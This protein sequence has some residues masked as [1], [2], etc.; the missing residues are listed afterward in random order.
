MSI[1]ISTLEM[2]NFSSFFFLVSLIAALTTMG[3]CSSSPPAA[4]KGGYYPSWSSLP[5]WEINTT[6]FTHIFYAFL[7]PSTVTFKFEVTNETA[8]AVSNFTTTLHYKN[9]P[10]KTLLSIGGAGADASALL[11]NLSSSSSSRK[12]FINSSM[13]VA[14]KFGFDGLDLD[15]EW[16]QNPNEMEDMGTLFK[17][18]R[19]AV[20]KESK[21]TNLPPLL[22]TAAVYFSAVTSESNKYPT[23]SITKNLDFINV[24]CYDYHGGWD[25]TLTGAQAAF[26]DP[27]SNISSIYGLK[28]WLGAGVPKEKLVIGLPLYGRT[29]TLKDPNNHGIG[30][31]AIDVGPG[32][33]GVLLFDEVEEFNRNSTATIVYDH[34]TVSTYSFFKVNSINTSWVSYDSVVSTVVKV[35][36]AQALGLRG[37]FFWALGSDNEWKITSQGKMAL[38]IYIYIYT[39]GIKKVM[40]RLMG[41][42]MDALIQT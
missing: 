20:K 42:V 35:A 32:D 11:A 39:R 30:A 28:S 17:E 25:P 38:P 15:W 5:P 23:K 13:E 10:V 33:L 12:I 26:F 40:G 4:V 3:A 24:M 34:D 2:A 14:R 41:R 16:P 1:S 22:L 18:W 19:A 29:W 7:S 6:F 27:S 21:A 8:I 37:Y 36:Y 31:A 9:P